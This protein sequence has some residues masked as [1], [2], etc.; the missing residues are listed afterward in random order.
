MAAP[1][2]A[3]IAYLSEELARPTLAEAQSFAAELAKRPGVAAILFYGSC[4]QKGTTEGV[5]DFYALTDGSPGAWGEGALLAAA[6]RALPPNVYVERFGDLRAKVAVVRLADFRAHAALGAIDT[7]FWARFCQR[8]AILWARDE[9]ARR[10]TV[11]AV[12]T[13]VETAAVWAARLAHAADGPAAWRA[14]FRKTYTVEI[15]P[16]PR[17]RSADIVGAD[18]G[19]FAA[20]W[21]LTEPARQAAPVALSFAWTLRWWAGKALHLSR[22][23]KAAF[24]YEGGPRYLLWKIARHRKRGT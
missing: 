21:P 15:R 6:G 1:D 8:A 23:A 11:E 3:L 22:L 7:T 16:E 13:A 4:L 14:L 10:Q 17:G 12:A 2:P 5:L 9:T 20:L 24:T 19:R 18:E